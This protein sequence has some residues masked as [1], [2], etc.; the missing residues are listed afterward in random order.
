MPAIYA[1]DRFG[2]DV[3]TRIGGTVKELVETR[4][5]AFDLGIQGPDLLFYYKPLIPNDIQKIG[6]RIHNMPGRR[7]F[8]RCGLIQRG[9]G[10][11]DLLAYLMGAVC[12]YTL[13][14]MLHP[15]VEQRCEAGDVIHT[16][17]EMSF[18][19]SLMVRD[20]LD[21]LTV[22][23][24]DNLESD[25]MPELAEGIRLFYPPLTAG[26]ILRAARSMVQFQRWM[27]MPNQAKRTA[28]S[29]ALLV[30][31]SMR[32]SLMGHIMTREPVAALAKSDEG[33]FEL[34]QKAV[35]AAP[36]YMEELILNIYQ[37]R[38]LGSFFDHTYLGIV[39]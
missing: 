29:G 13:D 4:R 26:H 10:E 11:D 12:H 9:C 30:T 31:G 8:N 32:R 24:G 6:A 5:L 3:I 14:V 18:D 25:E 22:P 23:V 2:Q 7:F 28:V 37:K 36:D 38:K 27:L 17:V 15:A 33:L 34:Y 20:G 35:E 39:K 16:E 21:P 1:H 19:R